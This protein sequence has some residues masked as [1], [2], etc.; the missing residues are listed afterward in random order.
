MKGE[1]LALSIEEV[2]EE[3]RLEI[4]GAGILESELEDAQLKQIV[5]KAMREMERFWDEST[6]VTVP[7]SSC[8][9]LT[10]WDHSSIVKV[11]RAN[12][13]ESN[14]SNS[15]LSVMSDPIY[16][17]WY[18]LYSNGSLYNISDYILNFAT[19]ST[20]SQIQ[21][22]LTTELSF[23]EDRHKNLLYINNNLSSGE[24]ITIEYIP[25]L[26]SVD[27]IKSDYW[28]S[29]LIKLSTALTKIIVGRIR[30]RFTQS[31]AI[32]SQD[33]DKL[34]EEG[35]SEFKELYEVLRNNS[36]YIY[37]ID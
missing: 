4:F 1:S 6:L 21:N 31:S 26:T 12:P 8:I 36:N 35:N 16:S 13:G 23:R 14:T 17:Q 20:L 34:L 5:H 28:I 30:T 19:Y 32:W 11:Y 27:E 7:F 37:G 15:T 24:L 29:I 10:G 18:S 25:K 33:G 3:I 2:I 22:T 9:D